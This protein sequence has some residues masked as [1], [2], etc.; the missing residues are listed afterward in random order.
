MAIIHLNDYLTTASTCNAYWIIED[1][2]YSPAPSS[3]PYSVNFQYSI[4]GVSNNS[5]INPSSGTYNGISIVL[6]FNSPDVWLKIEYT[7]KQYIDLDATYVYNCPEDIC[8]VEQR[9]SIRIQN[10]LTTSITSPATTNTAGIGL[11]NKSGSANRNTASNFGVGLIVTENNKFNLQFYKTV[12]GTGIYSNISATED[13]VQSIDISNEVAP[14]WSYYVCQ[15]ISKNDTLYSI[16]YDGTIQCNTEDVLGAGTGFLSLTESPST[17]EYA[18]KEGYRNYMTSSTNLGAAE[19]NNF[20]NGITVV[21]SLSGNNITIQ[22]F[23]K[24]H[25]CIVGASAWGIRAAEQTTSYFETHSNITSTVQVTDT[26][27]NDPRTT[28]KTVTSINQYCNTT[29]SSIIPAL[30]FYLY[31]DDNNW[32]SSTGEVARIELISSNAAFSDI[33]HNKD[34]QSVVDAILI[35]GTDTSSNKT[36]SCNSN[37]QVRFCHNLNAADINSIYIYKNN[38]I[39]TNKYNYPNDC[40]EWMEYATGDVFRIDII[41]KR[42]PSCPLTKTF[43]M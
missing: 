41:T 21:T 11:D 33:R 40:T 17:I 20:V 24:P 38:N 19:I 4:E 30:Y 13:T 1:I 39:V 25:Y 14:V 35:T 28:A 42:N 32:Y 6:P 12:K 16:Y 5:L 18:I 26:T 2:S 3:S 10:N 23:H 8:K 36:I 43:T 7:D 15:N 9:I 27:N 34:I 22:V 31:D 29:L 37:P